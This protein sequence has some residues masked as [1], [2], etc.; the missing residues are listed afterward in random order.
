MSAD[1][2]LKWL[3]VAGYPLCV[4]VG[5]LV[6]LYGADRLYHPG[7]TLQVS[8]TGLETSCPSP[9]EEPLSFGQNPSPRPL[10]DALRIVGQATQGMGQARIFVDQEVLD[11]KFAA[12]RVHPPSGSQPSLAVVRQLI[13]EAQASKMADICL[14]PSQGFV[15]QL[16]KSAAHP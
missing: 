9:Y 14:A 12:V 2:V 11:A 15:I 16:N 13:D 1:D 4:V 7:C 10:S 3:K 6:G 8:P 5:F